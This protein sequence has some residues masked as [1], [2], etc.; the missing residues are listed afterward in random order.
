[1]LDLIFTVFPM[2]SHCVVR[3]QIKFP[4]VCGV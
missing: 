4:S 2:R 1:M 3:L